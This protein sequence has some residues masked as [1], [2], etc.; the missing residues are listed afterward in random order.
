MPAT[1]ELTRYF[2]LASQLASACRAQDA[3]AAWEAADE[4]EVLALHGTAPAIR[5]RAHAAV[6]AAWRNAQSPAG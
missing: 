2:G 1:S 3:T 5:T 6:C 4:L